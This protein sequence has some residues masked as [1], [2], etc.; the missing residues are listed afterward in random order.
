MKWGLEPVHEQTMEFV[1]SRILTRE[2]YVQIR[3]HAWSYGLAVTL[4]FP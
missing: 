3:V 1:F 2:D 4:L